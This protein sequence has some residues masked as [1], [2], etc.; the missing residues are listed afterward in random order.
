MA[1]TK[2]S[3][4]CCGT[5]RCTGQGLGA[6]KDKTSRRAQK[7][8][9]SRDI[10]PVLPFG[11]TNGEPYTTTCRTP[12]D[13]QATKRQVCTSHEESIGRE[14][15]GVLKLKWGLWLVSF[16]SA[17]TYNIPKLMRANLLPG[18]GGC[19]PQLLREHSY[20]V[21]CIGW[22]SGCK[23]LKQTNERRNEKKR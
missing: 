16:G 10:R 7:R 8:P 20:D 1:R 22:L 21:L 6:S 4:P 5:P 18:T 3:A 13:T 12:L 17:S 2:P 14:L 15:H 19:I 23:G 9:A 11:V